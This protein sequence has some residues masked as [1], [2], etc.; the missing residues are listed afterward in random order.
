[1]IRISAYT[2]QMVALNDL[3]KNEKSPWYNFA[4]TPTPADFEKD[5]DVAMPV[6]GDNEWALPGKPWRNLPDAVKA[7]DQSKATLCAPLGPIA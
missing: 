2:G 7:K 1:M 3:I 6:C 4:C 5:G